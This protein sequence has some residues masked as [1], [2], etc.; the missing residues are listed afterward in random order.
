MTKW[1]YIE[2]DSTEAWEYRDIDSLKYSWLDLGEDF[3]IEMNVSRNV[4]VDNWTK[5]LFDESNNW[6]VI[7]KNN[8]LNYIRLNNIVICSSFISGN[9]SCDLNI[10]NSE[11]QNIKL[12]NG[13]SLNIWNNSYTLNDDFKI[14]PESIYIWSTHTYFSQINWILYDFKIYK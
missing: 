6:L 8:N 11:V 14:N 1:I 7:Y 2:S 13:D 5:F 4:L 12:I 3:A 9:T 10:D